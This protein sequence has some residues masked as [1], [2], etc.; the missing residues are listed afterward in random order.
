V[1]D[2]AGR[3]VAAL[4]QDGRRKMAR[5]TLRAVVPVPRRDGRGAAPETPY[6]R[7]RRLQQV[8]GWLLLAVLTLFASRR[9]TPGDERVRTAAAEGAEPAGSP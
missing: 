2:P 4:E 8:L 3:E 1:F 7:T 6:A 9:V 5:G